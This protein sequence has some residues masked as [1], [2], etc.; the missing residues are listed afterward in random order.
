[1]E[2]L[3]RL[4]EPPVL[5]TAGLVVLAVLARRARSRP[6]FALAVALLLAWLAVATPIGANVW[7]G[8]LEDRVATPKACEPMPPGAL[9]IVLAGGIAGDAAAGDASRLSASSLRRVL[10]AAQVAR[11]SPGSPVILS[12]GWGEPVREADLMRALM[13]D[14]GISADRLA[15]ERESRNTFENATAVAR[16]VAE[17]GWAARPAYLLTSALHLP[18][19]TATFRKAGIEACPIAADRRRE[20]LE[21]SSAW[22]PSGPALLNAFQALHEFIGLLAYAV[23]GRL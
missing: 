5:F 23:A 17:R 3:A 21:P 10:T 7:V 11:R 16:I 14:L 19:A 18:R 8:L 12:G 22:I 4:V 13:I 9:V 15:I 20:P 1:M 2:L 6:A